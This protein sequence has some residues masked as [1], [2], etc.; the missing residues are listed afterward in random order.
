[1][2]KMKQVQKIR[3]NEKITGGMRKKRA[4]IRRNFWD[5]ETYIQG[6]KAERQG[7]EMM[8]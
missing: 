7:K 2:T 4:M 8:Q 5:A 3:N 6:W 1:M